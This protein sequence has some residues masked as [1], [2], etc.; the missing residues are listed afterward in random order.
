MKKGTLL[1]GY[2]LELS[3]HLPVSVEVLENKKSAFL[4]TLSEKK[5]V[6]ILAEMEP[7]TLLAVLNESDLALWGQSL[8]VASLDG[9]VRHNA[10]VQPGALQKMV[11]DAD[12]W[13]RRRAARAVARCAASEDAHHMLRT[14]SGED[15]RKAVVVANALFW[16]DDSWADE[17]L[18]ELAEDDD[19]QVRR[20]AKE[21]TAN[22]A[23]RLQAR[24]LVSSFLNAQTGLDRWPFGKALEVTGDEDT[25]DQ[26]W[27]GVRD[28]QVQE[29]AKT[30]VKAVEKRL[31]DLARDI[32]RDRA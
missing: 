9:L 15:T 29:H 10:H 32:E 20:S 2:F 1:S 8:R 5:A 13:I 30:V 17:L 22:K 7:E 14:L 3:V 12:A 11:L 28:V 26:L 25:I 21:S 6:D 31:K 24:A 27:A 23:R 4:T 16:F 18:E 19:G